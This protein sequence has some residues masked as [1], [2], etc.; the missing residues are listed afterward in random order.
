[1]IF[2]LS[3]HE[4]V[5]TLP[6]GATRSIRNFNARFIRGA[7]QRIRRRDITGFI[8]Y[9]FLQRVSWSP[10]RGSE[11]I[12]RKSMCYDLSRNATNY[13]VDYQNFI[14]QL[15]NAFKEAQLF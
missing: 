10:E 1:M 3:M 2:K 4:S 5:Y 11:D 15:Y 7:V 12:L 9:N 14:N 6:H 8:E 13:L